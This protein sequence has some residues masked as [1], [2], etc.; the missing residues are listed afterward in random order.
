MF[1]GMKN[2]I[3]GILPVISYMGNAAG[4][5]QAQYDKQQQQGD[6]ALIRESLECFCSE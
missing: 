4:L 3:F 2:E 5:C 6:V 1:S